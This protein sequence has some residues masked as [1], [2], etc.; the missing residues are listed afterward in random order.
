MGLIQRFQTIVR[1]KVNRAL[2]AIEDPRETLDYAYERRREDIRKLRAS[3]LD[4]TTEKNRLSQQRGTLDQEVQRWEQA[5]RDYLAAGNDAQAAVAVERKQVAERQ[6]SELNAQIAS[7]EDD[8]QELQHNVTTL[9]GQLDTMRR[10]KEQI[11]A[12]YSA[13]KA[14]TQAQAALSSYSTRS[15]DWQAMVDRAQDRTLQVTSRA[16]ALSELSAADAARALPSGATDP[17]QAELARLKAEMP[18]ASTP[19]G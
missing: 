12:Q 13:A 10:Q 18:S 11:K 7:M 8:I 5:A 6:Q 3:I 19:A 1:G 14:Q 4:V 15:E 2:D 17:V 16:R 9:E